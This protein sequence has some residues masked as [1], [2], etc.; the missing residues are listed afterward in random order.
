[1]FLFRV[2]ASAPATCSLL[3]F[4]SPQAH[5]TK[6]PTFEVYPCSTHDYRL[7]R[8]RSSFALKAGM[9]PRS[10]PDTSKAGGADRGFRRWV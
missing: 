5:I 8:N 4:P 2:I 9:N 10:H 3:R 7:G 1:M 6:D